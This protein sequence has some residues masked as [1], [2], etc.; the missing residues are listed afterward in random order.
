MSHKMNSAKLS[1]DVKV[2]V[3][4]ANLKSLGRSFDMYKENASE[5]LDDIKAALTKHVDSETASIARMEDYINARH[6]VAME[7]GLK[8]ERKIDNTI[9]SVAGGLLV[10]LISVL[11]YIWQAKET[12]HNTDTKDYQTN[13]QPK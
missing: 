2:E 6:K 4:G 1:M 11:G 10:V 13:E 3:L 12:D 7:Q 8:A 9:R 5:K